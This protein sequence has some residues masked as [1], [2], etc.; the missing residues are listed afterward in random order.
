MSNKL[1]LGLTILV[2]IT[3]AAFICFGISR[4][5]PDTIMMKAVIVCLEC[6]GLGS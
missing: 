1:R 6:I 3:A 5:E 4:G 2:M